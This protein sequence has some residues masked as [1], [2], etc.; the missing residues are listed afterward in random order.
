MKIFQRNAT[1]IHTLRILQIQIEMKNTTII[2]INVGHLDKSICFRWCYAAA[3]I[4]MIM[5]FSPF[6]QFLLWHR[7]LLFCIRTFNNNWK[8]FSSIISF[9]FS[10]SANCC[11]PY[12]IAILYI[13]IIIKLTKNVMNTIPNPFFELWKDQSAI[14]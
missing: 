7:R 11:F 9:L 2:Y 14:A 4:L 3:L 8:W 13:Q 6:I 12:K 10:H 5:P 1:Y